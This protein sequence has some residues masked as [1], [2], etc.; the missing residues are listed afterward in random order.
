[1][2]LGTLFSGAC[3]QA[4]SVANSVSAFKAA[5]IFPSDQN[6]IRNQFF[7]ICGASETGEATKPDESESPV[8][9]S[10]EQFFDKLRS[11]ASHWTL[12]TTFAP[13]KVLNGM[14]DASHFCE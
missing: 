13:S 4:A 12:E 6:V 1:M 11:T 9:N 8:N 2:Q 14:S 7:S 3:K 5:G 10:P